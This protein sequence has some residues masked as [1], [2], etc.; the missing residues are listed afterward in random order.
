MR[1]TIDIPDETYCEL[2]IKAARERKPVR[3]IVL[4][5]LHR[6]L[7]SVEGSPIRKMRLPVIPSSR[8]GTL[9]LTNEQIDDLTAF[10]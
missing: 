4:R 3:E 1:T 2:K 5:A 10:S 9:S 7:E 8:P 6:E